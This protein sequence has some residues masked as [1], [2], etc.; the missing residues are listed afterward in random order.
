M[1]PSQGERFLLTPSPD[2]ILVPD[3]ESTYSVL[4]SSRERF[5][6]LLHDKGQE[7]SLTLHK[8][9]MEVTP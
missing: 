3:H 1:S 8:G 2:G 9:N 4:A 6:V 7:R 5:R